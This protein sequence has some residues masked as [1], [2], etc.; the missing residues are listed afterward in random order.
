[1]EG[2]DSGYFGAYIGCSPEKS[3]KSIAMIM[4]EFQKLRDKMVGAEE[5]DRAKRY[6]IGRH[7]IELQRTSS[8]GASILF[9]D[10]YGND[11]NETFTVSEHLRAVTPKEIQTLSEKIF[12]Q[13]PVISVVG[14]T[15]P[16]SA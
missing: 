1:M 7:D 9:D 16:L 2:L 6:L 12:A 13:Q 10:L 3:K 15:N 8:V 14:P 4:Q 11:L 5:L